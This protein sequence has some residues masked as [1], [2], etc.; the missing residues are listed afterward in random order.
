MGKL[1]R[2]KFIRNT[3]VGAAGLS[4]LPYLKA[5]RFGANDTIRLGI[6]GLGQQT[7]YLIYGFHAIPGIKIVAGCDIYDIK[8]ERFRM[9]V[10]AYQEENEQKV[11][12]DTYHH[13][14]EL[15]EREDIDAV[16]ICT[17]DHWH[18]FQAIDASRAGKDIY[19]EKPLAFTI[20]EGKRIVESV[21]ENNVV[22]GVGSQ[23]RSDPY[24]RHAVDMV[25]NGRIGELS[26]ISAHV[27]PPPEPYNLP[28]ETLPA[29]LDWNQWLGPNPFVHYNGDLNPPISL[30][31]LQHEQLWARWR[32]FR[33]TGGGFLCDWGAHNFDIGQW[34][35]G[36]DNSGPVEIIPANYNDHE[37][38]TFVY[39]NGVKMINEPFDE[40]N[41][42]GVKF[43]G[44]DGWIQVIRGNYQASDNSLLPPAPEDE[45][46]DIPY[47][48]GP[49]HL[50]NFIECVRERK[51]P[52][53]S[54]ETG[55]RS[56]SLGILGNI[57]TDLN[58]PL[59]WNPESEQ[60]VNDTEASAKLS[61]D[62]REGYI[63]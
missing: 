27:G 42:F 53:A 25:R 4:V 24:F 63:L 46:G 36:K 16:V 13:Y 44:S 49:E 20:E 38:I 21:R 19:L 15:L 11:E 45:E 31:P 7:R 48:G 30:D 52:V 59:R 57:A 33:E 14:Q 55:H 28:E 43:W 1:S 56:G 37:H 34:A 47:E 29:G 61:R 32:F 6:I 12:A 62:Y 2:R 5:C 54:V 60:F 18:A 41:N 23:Q 39:D 3:L 40:H 58:R 22:L 26:R 35:L 50:M 8:K 9:Q 10:G 17:P 51:D